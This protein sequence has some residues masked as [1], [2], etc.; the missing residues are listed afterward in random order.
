MVFTLEVVRF[1]RD[2]EEAKEKGGKLEHVGYMRAIFRTKKDAASYYDRHNPHMRSLNALNTF[3]SDWDPK[4]WLQYIVREEHGL[5][6]TVAPFDL[7]DEP[8]LTHL[9]DARGYT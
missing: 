4:T 8:V 6:D 2:M 1:I 7:Q 9:Q 5:I 3:C